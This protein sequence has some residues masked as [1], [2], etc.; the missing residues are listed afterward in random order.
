[1]TGINGT[2]SITYGNECAG[3]T[4]FTKTF[5]GQVIIAN[6]RCRFQNG[7]DSGSLL[8]QDI[9]TNP[10]AVGLCF[11]GSSIC[12]QSAIAIANP[13]NDVLS[14]AGATMVGQ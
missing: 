7:G 4:A 12:S 13:I 6:A 9:T 8:V 2:V 1:V 14:W 5:T 11:A 3:G 10:K